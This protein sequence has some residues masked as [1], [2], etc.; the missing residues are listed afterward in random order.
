MGTKNTPSQFDCY[1]AAEPDEP[2]FTLLARDDSAPDLVDQWADARESAIRLGLK[3]TS[4]AEKVAEARACAEDMRAWRRM[5]RVSA[6]RLIK[7]EGI[8]VWKA[9]D[10]VRGPYTAP[11]PTSERAAAAPIQ[12]DP[13]DEDAVPGPVGAD[14]ERFLSGI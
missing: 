5:H 13:G 8:P 4:D 7:S 6:P 2:Y 12:G 1:A 3:P 11:T 9:E 10:I 14:R